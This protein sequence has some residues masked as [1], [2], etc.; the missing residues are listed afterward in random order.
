MGRNESTYPDKSS[1]GDI[2]LRLSTLEVGGDLD[3]IVL[4]RREVVLVVDGVE[5]TIIE[6]SSEHVAGRATAIIDTG[7]DADGN[8]HF[9]RSGQR[10]LEGESEGV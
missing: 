4:V 6:N 5:C 3:G 7:G 9:L 8:A 10:V 2:N 1:V